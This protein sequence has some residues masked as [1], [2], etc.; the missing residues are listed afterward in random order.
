M[1]ALHVY[2]LYIGRV[3]AILAGVAAVAVFLYG[4]FLLMAVSHA[5]GI[6][7]T[8]SQVQTQTSELSQLEGT[9]LTLTRSLTRERAIEMGFV[10]PVSVATVYAETPAALSFNR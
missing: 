7:R 8:Q 1:K 10:K 5:A 4:T 9:Y 3:V 2:R 6:S